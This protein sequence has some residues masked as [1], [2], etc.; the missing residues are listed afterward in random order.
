MG[1]SSPCNESKV[2]PR[3]KTI[4]LEDNKPY[5]NLPMPLFLLSL[6][7]IKEIKSFIQNY[8]DIIERREN[9]KILKFLNILNDLNK[10]TKLI[11]DS[12]KRFQKEFGA[13][14]SDKNG[15]ELYDFA[16][17]TLDSEITI[18]DNRNKDN[19]LITKLF[20]F[21]IDK[22]C[23]KCQNHF[24]DYLSLLF[25]PMLFCDTK[26]ETSLFCEKCKQ[27]TKNMIIQNKIPKIIIS[28]KINLKQNRDFDIILKKGAAS[29]CCFNEK[30]LSWKAYENHYEFNSINNNYKK[31][32]I[33]DYLSKYENNN[34]ETIV[35]IY[36]SEE[37]YRNEENS[38][39]NF[40]NNKDY[41]SAIINYCQLKKE[42]R[43]EEKMYL[44]NKEY[45]DYLLIMNNFDI[46]KL[47]ENNI[48][49]LEQDINKNLSEIMNMNKLI[50]YDSPDKIIG[51]VDLINETI[52]KNL[53]FNNEYLGKEVKIKELYK[54]KIYKIIFKDNSVI[55]LVLENNRQI[56]SFWGKIP[57]KPKND[58]KL[59]INNN[60]INNNIK[61]G[62]N[63]NH[64]ENNQINLYNHQ[65]NEINNI[66]N[67]N[68]V[69]NIDN[70][71][72]NN[73]NLNIIKHYPNLEDN[74]EQKNKDSEGIKNPTVIEE[75]KITEK[76]FKINSIYQ[77]LCNIFNE[78]A[79]IKNMINNHII[80]ENKYE[81]FLIINKNCYN[82]IT[83]ILEPNEIY[84]NDKSFDKISDISNIQNI[85][86]TNTLQI[87]NNLNT[88]K[89]I[90][91]NENFYKI[92]LEK[93]LIDEKYILYPKDFLIMRENTIKNLLI[94]LGIKPEFI[95]N[96][97]YKLI[98]GEG[99]IFINDNLNKNIY[100]FPKIIIN[101]FLMLN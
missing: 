41:K 92:E 9:R 69:K 39:K 54:D 2:S 21:L 1:S 29:I 17:K 15:I 76:K 66:V 20:Y 40:V 93:I 14:I 12:V 73:E 55:K 99:K 8:Q 34:K 61:I 23:A 70:N 88:R 19:S 27:K 36:N 89:N 42:K 71:N 5:I 22:T 68:N 86:E 83:K 62:I 47:N 37:N 82:R 51:D 50:I 25:N 11:N 64:K 28:V 85:D 38:E 100:L 75:N 98:I 48:I 80:N 60:H 6:V 33:E 49:Y 63:N 52:L 4:T 24:H 96:N 13:K 18:I 72:P 65:S 45:F 84:E 56:I 78:I 53:G 81:E 67:F 30:S 91:S 35:Y 57:E 90:L 16:L 3:N 94:Q 101:Y 44:I 59:S 77:N 46:S 26:F 43:I 97:K 7:K 79:I 87:L 74:N 31:I 32:N 95:I 58:N 10:S